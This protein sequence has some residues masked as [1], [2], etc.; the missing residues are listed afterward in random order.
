MSE[1]TPYL[2]VRDSRSAIDWYQEV[3]DAVVSGQP[4]VMDDGR[5]GHVELT[6]DGA[7]FMMSD[8]FDE[9]GVAA[10]DPSRGSPLSLHLTVKDVDGLVAKAAEAG[11]QVD[12][13]PED[14]PNGR[15]AVLRDPFGHRWILNQL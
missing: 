14:T 10:P 9:A 5:V 11:A 7:P 4:F 3:F 13:I 1:L 2:C 15:I 8:P 12:R 6:I